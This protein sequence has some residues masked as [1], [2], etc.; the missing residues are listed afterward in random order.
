M[1]LESYLRKEFDDYVQDCNRC[2]K[3]VFTV[4]DQILSSPLSSNMRSDSHR[5]W[6]VGKKDV[7]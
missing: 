2:H 5:A 3:L 4:G 7:S 1:E 6:S